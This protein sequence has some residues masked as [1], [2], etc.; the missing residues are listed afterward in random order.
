MED[1]YQEKVNSRPTDLF[2]SSET[3]RTVEE[4]TTYYQI[5]VQIKAVETY[6]WS[7]NKDTAP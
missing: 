2:L 4:T 3:L 5:R 6:Y 7:L 1:F